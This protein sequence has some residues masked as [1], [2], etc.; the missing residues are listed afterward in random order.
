MTEYK[1][2]TITPHNKGF[3]LSQGTLPWISTVKILPKISCIRKT[4]VIFYAS[5]CLKQLLSLFPFATIGLIFEI[6]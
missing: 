3:E 1:G 5:C 4:A 6:V 2:F